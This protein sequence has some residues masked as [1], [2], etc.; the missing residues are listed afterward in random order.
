[1]FNCCICGR[2][3]RKIEIPASKFVFPE[4]FYQLNVKSAKV[5]CADCC[6]ILVGVLAQKEENLSTLTEAVVE[7]AKEW[8]E[9]A[10]NMGQI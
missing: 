4:V 3:P 7:A 9:Y 5:I 2:K 8:T 10:A 6:V 1:M